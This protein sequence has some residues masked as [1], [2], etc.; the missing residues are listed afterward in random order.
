MKIWLI[1]FILFPYFCFA[2]ETDPLDIPTK[3]YTVQVYS[4][5]DKEEA[6]EF[7]IKFNKFNKTFLWPKKLKEE[8]WYRV[9]VGLFNKKIQAD[10]QL[11]KIKKDFP[12]S[13]AFVSNIISD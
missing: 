10:A 9:C 12:D 3:A 7:G 8:S 13:D 6:R 11:E 4:S 2:Q 1:I 5:K